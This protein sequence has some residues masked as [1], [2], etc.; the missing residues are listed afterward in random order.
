M[1]LKTTLI[2]ATVLLSGCSTQPTKDN[3]YETTYRSNTAGAT[4]DQLAAAFYISAKEP[5]IVRTTPGAAQNV[6]KSLYAQGYRAIGISQFTTWIV[7]N[8]SDLLQAAKK[9][10]ADLVVTFSYFS[11]RKVVDMPLGN[12]QVNPGGFSGGN[13]GTVT[14]SGTFQGDINGQYSGTSNITTP[15]TYTPPT[16]VTQWGP[17]SLDYYAYETVFLRRST[18]RPFHY[19]GDDHK[20]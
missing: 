20:I 9:A 18:G 1:N 3:F 12:V 16:Y 17:T 5:E 8:D 2:I 10:G 11:G 19:T 14:S 6:F 4:K 7:Q 13:I 15:L